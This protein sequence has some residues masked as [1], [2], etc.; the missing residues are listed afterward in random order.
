MIILTFVLFIV[1]FAIK[2]IGMPDDIF[3]IILAVS[4]LWVLSSIATAIKAM[5]EDE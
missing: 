2:F 1:Y 4:F 3:N 5:E